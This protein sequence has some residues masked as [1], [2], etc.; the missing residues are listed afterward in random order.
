M[1]ANTEVQAVGVFIQLPEDDVNLQAQGQSL[2]QASHAQGS[3][4]IT[5]G[6]TPANSGRQ[7]A[8][9]RQGVVSLGETT[10]AVGQHTVQWTSETDRLALEVSREWTVPLGAGAI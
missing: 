3:V 8:A 10:C 9:Q 2:L 4:L 7:P 1:A 6:G 5:V